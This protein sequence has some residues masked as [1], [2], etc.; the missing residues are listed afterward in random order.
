MNGL[1]PAGIHE[2]RLLLRSLAD[3]GRTVFI[4]S[5]LLAEIEQICDRL[6]VIDHGR[7]VFEGS[8]TELVSGRRGVLRVAAEDPTGNAVLE[9][10]CAEAGWSCIANGDHF[11]VDAPSSSAAE[12]NRRAMAAGVALRE[13]HYAAATLEETFLALTKEE[14]S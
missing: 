12:L 11:E 5:H 7:I 10:I 4:S 13:L 8:T 14:R 2:M 3:Q 6:V 1:D 9:R